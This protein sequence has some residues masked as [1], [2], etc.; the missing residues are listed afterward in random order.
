MP[1][2]HGEYAPAINILYK[3]ANS[4]CICVRKMP[5]YQLWKDVYRLSSRKIGRL[6]GPTRLEMMMVMIL[7]MMRMI[8]EQLRWPSSKNVRLWRCGLEFDSKSGQ[9]NGCK[10]GIHSFPA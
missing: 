3:P 6:I 5:H 10:I 1:C 8:N 9:T 2:M 4:D 7:I